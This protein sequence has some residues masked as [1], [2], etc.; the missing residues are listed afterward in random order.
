[1]TLHEDH[2]VDQYKS[3]CKSVLSQ[4]VNKHIVSKTQKIHNTD[5][6]HTG[7]LKQYARLPLFTVLINY[8]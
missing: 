5:D 1:M 3:M 6:Q 8:M 2:S 7:R 4:L